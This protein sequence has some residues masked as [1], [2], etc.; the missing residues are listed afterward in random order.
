VGWFPEQ[1]QHMHVDLGW[2]VVEPGYRF[3]PVK[4]EMGGNH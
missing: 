1:Q 2:A 3:L 4:P